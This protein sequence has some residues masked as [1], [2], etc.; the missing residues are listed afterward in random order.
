M[1][2]IADH[3]KNDGDRDMRYWEKPADFVA[4]SDSDSDQEDDQ[5]DD[6]EDDNDND[7]DGTGGD[8]GQDFDH[9]LNDAYNNQEQHPSSSNGHPGASGYD[10]SGSYTISN[11]DSNLPDN[12]NAGGHQYNLTMQASPLPI[13][14][15]THCDIDDGTSEHPS[16][17]ATKHTSTAPPILQEINKL[18]PVTGQEPEEPKVR[19]TACGPFS[20]NSYDTAAGVNR[21]PRT[22][23]NLISA[24]KRI[25]GTFSRKYQDFRNPK[26]I[27]VS[28]QTVK[29]GH[30][31]TKT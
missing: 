12:G 7:D 19:A 23:S 13:E 5:E 25:K 28:H 24:V 9:G 8:G 10:Y 22:S 11:G 6:D 17:Q 3:Y 30:Y 31:E 1:N 20:N 18:S 2:H 29:S 27:V 16:N 4:D 21:S 26:I 14:R 15:H